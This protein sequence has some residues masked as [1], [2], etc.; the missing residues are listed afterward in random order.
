MSKKLSNY[1]CKE[2]FIVCEE[3]D[4]DF[5]EMFVTDNWSDLKTHLKTLTPDTDSEMRVFHGVIT[6]AEFLPNSFHGKSVF[7]VCQDPDDLQKGNAIEAVSDTPEGLS[8]DISRLLDYGTVHLF[9]G[10]LDIDNV[11]LLYGYQLQTCLTVD[12][13]ELDEEIIEMCKII[14]TEV[15]MTEQAFSKNSQGG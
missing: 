6:P 8:E 4:Q 1:T 13:D 15:K 7:I 3:E 9:N 11:Y 12:G 10:E 5:G 2:I 14:G